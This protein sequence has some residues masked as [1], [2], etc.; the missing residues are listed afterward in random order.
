[1]DVCTSIDQLL[2]RRRN[3]SGA[4][5]LIPT[6]GALHRGHLSLIDL[7]RAQVG[8][9]GTVL[10]SL[11]VNP[12]QFAPGEDL[13]RYPRPFEADASACRER[14]V[15][16]LFAPAAAD[17]YAPDHS[18]TV[19]ESTLST[20]LCGASR[21]GH[22]SGVCTV[23]L[24]LLLLTRPDLAVF[25]NKDY[26]QLAVIR[27]M[28]RDLNVPAQ[29]VAAP[30]VRE[31]DGL[32]LSSRNRYLSAAERSQ[33]PAL[34]RALQQARSAFQVGETNAATLLEIATRTIEQE[35]PEARI[36]YLQ[37]VDRHRLQTM[38]QAD[39]ESVLLA[40]IWLGQTRLIDN[41]EL[42]DEEWSSP[43]QPPPPGKERPATGS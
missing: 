28:M 7:A 40:A 14:G 32:A 38:P 31:P 15:D 3:A 24:K 5:A 35:A 11:F 9:S 1:M 33:A 8:P 18:T 19:E 29:V 34:Q 26:Q 10:V 23:V 42:V 2:E 21:P 39:H 17:M 41:L 20:G 36:D 4:I 13:E 22:F 27:R 12:T 37:L 30:T 25:G 16:I 6:M 43:K